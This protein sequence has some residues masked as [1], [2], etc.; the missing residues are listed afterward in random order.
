MTTETRTEYETVE[1]E[2]EVT[3]C[4]CCGAERDDADTATVAI[5]PE[6]ERRSRADNIMTSH[7]SVITEYDYPVTP[8][9]PGSHPA[10]SELRDFRDELDSLRSIPPGKLTTECTFDVCHDCLDAQFD[11][12]DSAWDDGTA[13][14]LSER[15]HDHPRPKTSDHDGV[16]G[17]WL[18]PIGAFAA[19]LSLFLQVVDMLVWDIA[20][21]LVAQSFLLGIAV[22]LGLVSFW[23]MVS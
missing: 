11:D 7:H 19:A 21:L 10:W 16:P 17:H 20:G 18:L 5:N 4:D 15:N 3:I 2:I 6:Y 1:T 8:S 23:G 9:E 13:I 22:A 14:R 12:S